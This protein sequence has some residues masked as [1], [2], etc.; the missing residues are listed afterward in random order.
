MKAAIALAASAVIVGGSAAAAI[1]LTSGST[2]YAPGMYLY[3]GNRDTNPVQ[4]T[5]TPGN[6]TWGVSKVPPEIYTTDSGNGSYGTINIGTGD[7]PLAPE[8]GGP[9]PGTPYPGWWWSP[10]AIQLNWAELSSGAV[11]ENVEGYFLGVGNKDVLGNGAYAPRC[12]VFTVPNTKTTDT[13][14]LSLNADY[15]WVAADSGCPG[16]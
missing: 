11:V 4:L 8:D 7:V 6:G 14:W 10:Q 15:N 12:L 9:A 1:A 5:G 3:T 2:S 13:R 16:K